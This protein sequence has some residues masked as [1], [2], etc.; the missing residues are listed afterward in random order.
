[1]AKKTTQTGNDARTDRADIMSGEYVPSNRYKWE[2]GYVLYRQS[3][4]VVSVR[5]KGS[6][7][8]WEGVRVVAEVLDGRMEVGEDGGVV[9]RKEGNKF[10]PAYPGRCEIA[11]IDTG[12]ERSGDLREYLKEAM[13]LIRWPTDMRMYHMIGVMG[14]VSYDSLPVERLEK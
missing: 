7:K 4:G 8:E 12:A 3:M 2:G 11:N 6:P 9:I 1:M 5:F 14:D 10:G 13:S